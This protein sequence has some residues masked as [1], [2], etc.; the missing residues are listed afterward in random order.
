MSIEQ[1]RLS[2]AGGSARRH[3]R[4]LT[5]PQ[6]A[7][8]VPYTRQHVG[9]L[10][11]DDRF[12]KRLQI[13]PGRVGWWESEVLGWL[14]ERG[15]GAL[16]SWRNRHPT[17]SMPVASNAPAGWPAKPRRGERRNDVPVRR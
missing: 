15:R 7:A 12:P 17:A 13:G 3:D 1:G 14:H 6:V 11:A 9:R 5:W 2:D 10:E 16:R 8:L 4:V